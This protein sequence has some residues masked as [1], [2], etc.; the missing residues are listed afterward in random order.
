[1]YSEKV[2]QKMAKSSL[3]GFLITVSLASLFPFYWMF[4]MATNS[5]ETINQ[6]PPALIPGSELVT[7]FQNVL[8]SIPFFELC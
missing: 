4:V 3:Y 6:T 8:G 7:N 2:K 5:N 1:M